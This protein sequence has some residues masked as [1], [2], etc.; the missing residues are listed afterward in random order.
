MRG[1]RAQGLL[2]AIRLKAYYGQAFA[3]VWITEPP[4]FALKAFLT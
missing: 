3:R 1:E 2:L 4:G